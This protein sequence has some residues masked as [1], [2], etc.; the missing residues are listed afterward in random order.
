MIGLDMYIG[1]IGTAG[2]GLDAEKINPKLWK[3]ML[4]DVENRLKVEPNDFP[5]TSLFDIENRNELI[6][7]SG[8]AALSDHLA[9]QAF[10]NGW[11]SGLILYMPAEWNGKKFVE[12]SGKFDCGRIANYYHR[13]FSKKA[14]IDSLS[15][16]E[17]VRKMGAKF[18][19]NLN[20]F[21]ARNK[22]VAKIVNRL[23]AYTF[24]EGEEPG[25]GGT[26]HTWGLCGAPKIHVS[27]LNY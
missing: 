3:K 17:E 27:L 21:K 6:L 13:N 15:Q 1:I 19:V 7:V 12:G 18:I 4:V 24:N 5:A 9:V 14:K 11:A 25:D 20:G 26:A 23:I 10:L 16:L 22:Q 8:G 2:R